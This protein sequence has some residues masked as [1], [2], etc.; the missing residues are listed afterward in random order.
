MEK[1]YNKIFR[2]Q[3]YAIGIALA[4]MMLTA[5]TPDTFE[6][7][8]Q[9][10]I[11]TVN[12]VDFTL[13]VD[14]ENNQATYTFEETPGVY[15]I[16]IIDGTTYSTLHTAGYSNTEA[17]TH[18]IEL[19]LG[20]RNG[21]SQ[22]SVVKTFTFNETKVDYTSDFRKITGKEWRIA[23]KETAHL[24]C[25]PA[26]TDGAG[27]WAASA[28]DKAGT[29]LYDDR[30]TFTADNNKGG[31][32]S[33]SPGE[34]GLTYVNTGTTLWGSSDADFDV[35]I[36]SQE[37]TWSF[38]V[39]DWEDSEG[40][41][42]QVTYI[43]LA[44]NTLFPY[45][46]SDAQYENPKFRIE[47]LTAKKMVL[48]YDA[49]DRSIA[50]R[51]ILT[52]E[53]EEKEFEGFDANSNCNMFKDMPYTITFWYADENW[54]QL[55]DPALTS[56]TNEWSIYLPTAN[57]D[58]WQTQMAFHT[59]MTTNSVTN[60]DFSILL[61]SDK[62]LNGATV[63]LTQ[64]DDDG[65][66]YFADRIDLKA[67]EE[68]VFW[69]SDM[70]G[71]DIPN[72]KLVLDFGGC[73]EGTTIDI[74]NIVLKE[75]DCDD[76][77]KAPENT[78]DTK[79]AVMDWDYSSSS[80]LWFPIYESKLAPAFWYAPGWS[81]IGDPAF[82]QDGD[83]YTVILPEATS[84]QWMAQ[85]HFDT[86]I[87]ALQSD[88]YNFYCVLESDLDHPG[89]TVKLTDANSDENFFFADRI[90]LTAG[91]EY[92]YKKEGV[93]LSV[94][95]AS[96]LNLFFDFGGNAAGNTIT[97]SKIYLEKCQDISYDSSSNLWKS[98]DESNPTPAF[99]YAPGWSQ[100]ADPTWTHNGS[101]WTVTLPEATTDQWMAQMHID[102]QLSALQSDK[103]N[104]RCV[105]LADQ[106]Q[107]GV[108]VKLTDAN[109]DENF[110]FAE[111]IPLT[112]DEEYVFERSGVQLGVGDASGLN[113]FFDFGGNPA[114]S[115]ITIKEI[116][117]G[118]YE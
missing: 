55:T 71:I 67:G 107:P 73:Q 24:A 50:W 28:D 62:D 79:K 25:G 60:Y 103:Y 33:Y 92:I 61:T 82:S 51:F 27:W 12:G 116:Y 45:I 58:Q 6:G 59:S 5:C 15:P 21:F 65:I 85:M 86:Q 111:R 36:G 9:S 78:E 63:K 2:G 106:D 89:V 99:W 4:A 16:W 108:T 31:T 84:D 118:K 76:G 95:D 39:G 13:E 96:A 54:S 29:G 37:S 98:I 1:T 42:S 80:N 10:G 38:A 70:A 101:E 35:A 90:P 44:A 11:P 117:F 17:G 109:S 46:S 23:N 110:F 93:Q 8:D 114:N 57:K 112:A 43:Q 68:Y 113:L 88:K 47:T 48:V 74:S 7:A 115:T 49:P 102:T 81:Q 53:E 22:G 52:S 91:E 19:K 3:S 32:Y 64:E 105:L 97:I 30:I 75:H 18:T 41:V 26:G 69:K 14:Q 77:T 20:N 66:F 100:I 104:F 87:S 56:G 94:G 72:I 83:V 40:N 34:D